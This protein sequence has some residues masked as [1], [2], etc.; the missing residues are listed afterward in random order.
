M[1]MA[2]ESW[3]KYFDTHPDRDGVPERDRFLC[4]HAPC[5]YDAFTKRRRSRPTAYLFMGAPGSGKSGLPAFF[6]KRGANPDECLCIDPDEYKK[7]LPE[8]EGGSGAP[9]V[10]E[11]SSW[12]ARQVR[13]I[14]IG[15]Q[16]SLMN[17]G[18]GANVGKYASIIQR[19]K[20]NAYK[21]EL[22]CLIV[23]DINILIG[24]V[25]VRAERTGRIVPESD[26]RK[27][28]REVPSCFEKLHRFVDS[29]FLLD[30]VTGKPV[31][32]RIS[33]RTT[34]YDRDFV[35]TLGLELVR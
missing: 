20:E 3:E 16:C 30:G 13:A 10:H 12:I 27:A 19:L 6:E 4:S 28:H 7:L 5:F 11:E 9:A 23:L 33:G 35:S 18:V 34:V 26:V 31:W 14:A 8:Y 29:A 1:R 15:R 32:S 2:E 25:A 22:A 24:R 21:V 17:D